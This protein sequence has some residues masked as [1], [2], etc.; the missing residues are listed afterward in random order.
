MR[1]EKSTVTCH[2][3][4]QGCQPDAGQ[5]DDQ[6]G[7]EDDRPI[8][9]PGLLAYQRGDRREAGGGHR[10]EEEVTGHGTA[11]QQPAAYGL[12]EGPGGDAGLD[13]EGRPEQPGQGVEQAEVFVDELHSVAQNDVEGQRPQ[14]GPGDAGDTPGEPKRQS[15]DQVPGQ[16]HGYERGGRDHFLFR[17]QRR[18][19]RTEDELEGQDEVEAVK[20]PAHQG[21]GAG[22]LE[23]SQ[24]KLAARDRS[25]GEERRNGGGP[26]SGVTRQPEP[27]RAGPD[28]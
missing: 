10:P 28:Q 14:G 9:E 23:F 25:R 11:A 2:G 12:A 5:G 6:D 16:G 3:H 7:G 8:V 15:P 13:D 24:G 17:P 20:Q 27:A 26:G 21:D 22:Q 1:N 19:G 18:V 4:A